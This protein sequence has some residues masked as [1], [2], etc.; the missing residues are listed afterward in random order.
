MNVCPACA[1][2]VG[3]NDVTC[4][5]CGISLHPGTATA[6]PASG[7]SGKGL[8]IVAIAV[9]AVI[10]IVILVGCL[11]LVGAGLFFGFRTQAVMSPPPSAVPYGASIPEPLVET[12]DTLVSEPVSDSA[13]QPPGDQRVNEP[14][15]E[16]P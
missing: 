10:G 1:Q 13:E 15:K 16:T 7:G 5:K 2:A 6:G 9:I 8:S 3:P 4:S 11:G 14:R 12:F